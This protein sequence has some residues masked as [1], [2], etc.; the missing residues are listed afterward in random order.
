MQKKMF[1]ETAQVDDLVL[2]LR[3]CCDFVFCVLYVFV[4]IVGSTKSAA[5]GAGIT[6]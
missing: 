2:F 5:L 1:Y 6:H 4:K 3:N